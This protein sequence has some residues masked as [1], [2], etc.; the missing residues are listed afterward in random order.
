MA[1]VPSVVDERLYYDLSFRNDTGQ[2]API[3]FYE[4]RASPYLEVPGDWKLAV[5][6]FFVNTDL[7]PLFTFQDNTYSVTLGYGADSYRSYLAFPPRTLSPSD[8]AIRTF[9]QFVLS[10]N[11]ALQASFTALKTAHPGVASTLPPKV[12]FDVDASLF[13]FD[14]PIT[15]VADSISVWM[16]PALEG[17]LSQYDVFTASTDPAL[18]SGRNYQVLQYDEGLGTSPSGYYRMNQSTVSLDDWYSARSLLFQSSLPVKPTMI[19]GPNNAN[20]QLL[21]DFDFPIASIGGSGDPFGFTQF[22]VTGQY[23]YIDLMGTAPL[24]TIDLTISWQDKAG[25]ITP[26]LIPP[27]AVATVKILFEKKQKAKLQD[28]SIRN[29]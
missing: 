17:I 4:N 20:Q 29:L 27:G 9:N 6:R 26:L 13:R 14:I 28:P 12:V 3:S 7:I 22:A 10:V 21:T 2:P 24:R 16:N 25:T 8:R 23:R 11:A 18:A 5:V 19:T 1:T 15:Y